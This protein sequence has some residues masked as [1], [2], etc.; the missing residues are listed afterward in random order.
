M[1][2]PSKLFAQLD[3]YMAAQLSN[4]NI[5]PLRGRHDSC[6]HERDYEIDELL[7]LS[8]RSYTAVWLPVM[9]Q[10]NPVDPTQIAP[11]TRDTWRATRRNLLKVINRVSYRSALALYMFSLTPTPVRIS[12][13]EELDGINANLSTYT[14][15]LKIQQLRQ[16][17]RSFQPDGAEGQSNRFNWYE[18]NLYYYMAVFIMADVL[19]AAQRLDVLAQVTNI[20]LEAEHKSFNNIKFGLENLY[21]IDDEEFQLGPTLQSGSVTYPVSQYL[22]TSFVAIDPYPHFVIL[23]VRLITKA[24]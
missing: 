9:L 18:V 7:Q 12:A 8:V 23:S 20:R 10:G 21:T 13:E 16:R 14:A 3:A 19:E 4:E 6:R 1:I 5:D 22:R 11:V 17:L 15:L 2:A 24:S